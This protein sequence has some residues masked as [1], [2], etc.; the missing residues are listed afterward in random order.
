M[1]IEKKY[2]AKMKQIL[3]NSKPKKLLRDP[4]NVTIRQAHL[5]GK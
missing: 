1:D 3:E 2:F 4:V 5:S